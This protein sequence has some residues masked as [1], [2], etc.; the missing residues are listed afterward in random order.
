MISVVYG[1]EE[2]SKGSAVMDWNRLRMSSINSG[3]DDLAVSLI[4]L[5]AS[6]NAFFSSPVL[7]SNRNET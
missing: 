6:A 3:I 4:G 2:P 5:R 7:E 1:I